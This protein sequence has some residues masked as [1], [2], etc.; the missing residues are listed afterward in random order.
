M[1]GSRARLQRG[2]ERCRGAVAVR[3]TA[4]RRSVTRGLRAADN[5]YKRGCYHGG[6][7]SLLSI[8]FSRR[9]SVFPERGAAVS[10]LSTTR[11]V[12]GH[13]ADGLI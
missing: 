4:A 3:S 12:M 8:I 13:F 9:Y 1:C 10:T 11:V 5:E 6:R 2:V 7:L